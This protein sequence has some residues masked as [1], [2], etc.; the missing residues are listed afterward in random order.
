MRLRLNVA[1]LAIACCFAVVGCGGGSSGTA[2]AG[3]PISFEELARSASSSADATSG[4]FGFEM[5]MSFAGADEPFSFSGEGAFDTLSKR[6]SFS[7]DMSSLPSLLGGLFAGMGGTAGA[8]AP[9]FDAPSGWKIDAIQ[10]GAVGYVHFPALQGELPAGK[11]WIRADGGDFAVQGLD[12]S[13]LD[14]FTLA[15]QAG[16]SEIPVDIWLDANGL[17]RKLTMVFSATQSGRSETGEIS[18]TFE[19]WDYGE[20][21]EIELPPAS[22]VVDASAVRS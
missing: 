20:A 7:V 13:V 16:L 1:L 6:A 4:R 8:N 12:L 9:D 15:A 14:Q 5:T 19:L 10:D 18:M 11:S 21:V 3:E 22:E 17:V 2:V